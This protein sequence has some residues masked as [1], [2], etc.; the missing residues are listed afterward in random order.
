M[1]QDGIHFMLIEVILYHTI[2]TNLLFFHISVNTIQF[3]PF[4]IIL[5][6]TLIKIFQPQLNLNLTLLLILSTHTPLSKLSHNPNQI[7]IHLLLTKIF[8]LSLLTMIIWLIL[9][10]LQTL[11]LKCSKTVFIIKMLQN[12]IPHSNS[13]LTFIPEFLTLQ[14]SLQCPQQTLKLYLLTFELLILH[15]ICL[16]FHRKVTIPPNPLLASLPNFK[17]NIVLPYLPD[18]HT[19]QTLPATSFTHS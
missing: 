15:I 8:L 18:L 3:L 12:R 10:I 7:F 9:L 13:F 11:I 17:F 14:I 19:Y 6:Q 16:L 5:I 1:A 4:L 2:L